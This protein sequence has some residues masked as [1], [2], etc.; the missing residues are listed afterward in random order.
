MWSL[1]QSFA[2]NHSSECFKVLCS[3]PFKVDKMAQEK[4]KSNKCVVFLLVSV[5]LRV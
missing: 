1:R 2:C 3:E 5:K 4:K